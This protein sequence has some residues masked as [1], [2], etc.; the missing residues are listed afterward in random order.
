[1][2]ESSDY[3]ADTNVLIIEEPHFDEGGQW[4]LYEG[5]GIFLAENPSLLPKTIFLSEG[6]PRGSIVS[7]EE[8]RDTTPAG[9]EDDFL[10]K[11]FRSFLI[12]GYIGLEWKL[13]YNIPIVGTENEKLYREGARLWVIEETADPGRLA[14]WKRSVVARNKSIAEVLIEKIREYGNPILFVGGLHLHDDISERRDLG[15]RDYLKANRIGYTFL[16]AQDGG[17][18]KEALAQSHD[19]YLA[20]FEAQENNDYDEYIGW[21]LRQD[22][23]PWRQGVAGLRSGTTVQPSAAGAAKYIRALKD[24]NR[25]ERRERNLKISL[26]WQDWLTN[27]EKWRKV[28]EKYDSDEPPG[29]TSVWEVWENGNTGERLGVHERKPRTRI[30]HPHPFDLED[31]EE[32]E[33]L[34]SARCKDCD[35]E[36]EEKGDI[37]KRLR[38]ECYD[39]PWQPPWNQEFGPRKNCA[40]CYT[41]CKRE[42]LW[43]YNKCPLPGK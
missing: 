39:N 4:N 35:E 17:L 27:K 43:P 16:V 33:R 36:E 14:D 3:A 22:V 26:L 7:V 9:P 24:A 37:C 11:V 31:P 29:H 21:L 20:L 18:A 28:A 40:D 6:L 13:G 32:A 12:P 38:D 23:L 5:L 41:I 10:R 42:G 2:I 30:D 19:R 15:L 8:L 1:V 25:P 34:N